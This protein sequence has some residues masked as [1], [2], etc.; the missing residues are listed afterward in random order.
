MLRDARHRERLAGPCPI[1]GGPSCC[2]WRSPEPDA[3]HLVSSPDT[4]TQTTNRHGGL[5]G[6]AR[7][8]IGSRQPCSAAAQSYSVSARATV[9]ARSGDNAVS[10]TR[11]RCQLGLNERRPCKVI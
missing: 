1:G 10:A 4:P 2:T 6:H 11:L 3:G 5:F 8:S 7:R 9:C